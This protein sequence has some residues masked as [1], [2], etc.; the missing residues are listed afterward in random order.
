MNG[1]WTAKVI[2]AVAGLALMLPTVLWTSGPAVATTTR[3]SGSTP[4][5]ST[6]CGTG[7]LRRPENRL[8][9]GRSV[10]RTAETQARS[11]GP[12]TV[13]GRPA[14]MPEMTIDPASPI[15]TVIGTT[16]EPVSS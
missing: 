8:T 5:R 7:R 1:R 14:I 15:T 9:A 6:L 10:H 2:S 16:Q 12:P 4:D 13:S 11:G 3:R